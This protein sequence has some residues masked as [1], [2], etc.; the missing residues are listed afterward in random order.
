MSFMTFEG[1]VWQSEKRSCLVTQSI[2]TNTIFAKR[3]AVMNAIPR[4]L[5]GSF[6]NAMRLQPHLGMEVFSCSPGCCC[7]GQ[8]EVALLVEG[9]QRDH[10]G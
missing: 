7:T 8:D 10:L 3:G 5:R 1:T 2:Y 4:F 9:R 6:R